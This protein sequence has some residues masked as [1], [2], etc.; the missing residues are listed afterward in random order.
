M[1]IIQ[2][3]QRRKEEDIDPRV[4]EG[5]KAVNKFEYKSNPMSV[6]N[7]FMYKQ[8]KPRLQ[9]QVSDFIFGDFYKTFEFS[10]EGL[11]IQ[12]RRALFRNCQFEAYLGTH[13]ED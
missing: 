8:L 13:L 7:T 9:D 3:G 4:V 11:S 6:L 1:Y 2:L 12:F 10:L 5:L